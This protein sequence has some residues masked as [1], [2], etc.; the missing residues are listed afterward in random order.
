[1]VTANGYDG[2]VRC[3]GGTLEAQWDLAKPPQGVTPG[4]DELGQGGAADVTFFIFYF[5]LLGYKQ[6]DLLYIIHGLRMKKTAM[7]K[8]E[9]S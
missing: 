5:M 8:Q 1:M 7:Q 3:R 4:V 2:K 6:L 9:A